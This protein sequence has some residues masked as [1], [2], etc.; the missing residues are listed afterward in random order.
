[1]SF[2]LHP[3]PSSFGAEVLGLDL[4]QPVSDEAFAE[5]K[6]AL[7]ENG[8]LLLANQRLEPAHILA[9]SRRFGA[10]ETHVE[11]SFLLPGYREIVVIG[12]LMVDGQMRS[13]FV[14]GGEEWHYDYSYT[15]DAS[16]AALFYAVE[17]PRF[18][19]WLTSMLSLRTRPS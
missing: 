17:V 4:S 1:M 6:A 10:L 8:F 14:N 13:L 5:V 9:W 15:P 3:L 12:N 11:A 16:I 2:E 7:L 19:N 18:T